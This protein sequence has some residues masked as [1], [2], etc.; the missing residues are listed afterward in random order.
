MFTKLVHAAALAHE[1]DTDTFP[2]DD[3]FACLVILVCHTDQLEPAKPGDSDP[4]SSEW[5]YGTPQFGKDHGYVTKKL[6]EAVSMWTKDR[7]DRMEALK[8]NEDEFATAV[9]HFQSRTKGIEKSQHITV[10]CSCPPS[11][12]GH[13]PT[14][15]GTSKRR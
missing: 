12:Q 11:H 7:P 10:K 8:K 2:D 9:N 6:P 14:S 15:V 4:D 5:W 1:D 13:L 3:Q